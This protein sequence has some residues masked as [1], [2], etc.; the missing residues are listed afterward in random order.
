M[1]RVGSWRIR[2]VC[3]IGWSAVV[4]LFGIVATLPCT[5]V[6]LLGGSFCGFAPALGIIQH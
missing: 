1:R 6:G 2:R 5:F 4:G 3:D